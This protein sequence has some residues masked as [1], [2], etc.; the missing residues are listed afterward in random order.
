MTLAQA[1]LSNL[2]ELLRAQRS[3]HDSLFK[4]SLTRIW[5]I[6]IFAKPIDYER[7]MRLM[8]TCGKRAQE[9]Q[10]FIRRGR[11]SALEA[12]P[13]DGAFIDLVPG[14]LNR[15]EE[16]C[17]ALSA[18]AAFRQRIAEK[19]IKGEELKAI[20]DTKS[21]AQLVKN[22]ENAQDALTRE[23]VVLFAAWKG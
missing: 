7:I 16:A 19:K 23:G 9:Q 15:F 11:Q 4:F 14:Y 20:A 1:L 22:Y 21:W 17:S 2:R 6:S 5:P 12:N 18:C 3:C 8:D 10:D 13:A